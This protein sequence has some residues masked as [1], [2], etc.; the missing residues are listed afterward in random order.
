MGAARALPEGA[1]QSLP[2]IVFLANEGLSEGEIIHFLLLLL[3]WEKL[4][5]EVGMRIATHS[6]TGVPAHPHPTMHFHP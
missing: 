1:G 3:G 6:V 5:S 2:A 4:D